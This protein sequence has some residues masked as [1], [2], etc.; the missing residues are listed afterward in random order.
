MEYEDNYIRSYEYVTRFYNN[1]W[2]IPIIIPMKP[3]T[4]DVDDWTNYILYEQCGNNQ[5]QG[6]NIQKTLG[7]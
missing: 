6:E 3:T 7:G 2:D 4:E 1:V 5:K